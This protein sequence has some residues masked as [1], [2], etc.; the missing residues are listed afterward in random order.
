MWSLA[1]GKKVFNQKTEKDIGQPFLKSICMSKVSFQVA[2][3]IRY[4]VIVSFVI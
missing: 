1:R 4:K 3:Y 2:V